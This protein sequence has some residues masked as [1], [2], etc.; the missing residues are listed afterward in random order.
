MTSLRISLVAGTCLAV[1]AAC[2]GGTTQSSV[3]VGTTEVKGS[4]GGVILDAT[5]GL[6]PLA[7]VAVT[8]VSGA[9]VETATTD[10]KGIFSVTGIPSGSV[11]IR[12]ASMGH[13]D[14]LLTRTLDGSAGNFP[15][16]NPAL[17]IGP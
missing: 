7:G 15:L 9:V 4:V 12:L 3:N 16:S 17:T 6:A 1:T 8:V 13:F 10:D 11:V 14:V 2:S 5:P